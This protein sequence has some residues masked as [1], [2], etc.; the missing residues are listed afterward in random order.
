VELNSYYLD[1]QPLTSLHLDWVHKHLDHLDYDYLKERLVFG[2]IYGGY[3]NGEICGSVGVHAEGSIG[4]LQVLDKYRKRGFASELV[5][6][7]TNNLLVKG[8]VPFSQIE[9]DNE[10]SV[11]LH[12]KLG[13]EILTNRIYRLID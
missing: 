8:E 11:D 13:F 2:S 1:I 12:R 4:L 10:S 5:T 3:I 6:Y 9:F 7:M